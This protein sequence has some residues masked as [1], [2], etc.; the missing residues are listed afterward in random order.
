MK[1]KKIL[2]ATFLIANL[3]ALPLANA[4]KYGWSPCFKNNI[5]FPGKQYSIQVGMTHLHIKDGYYAKGLAQDEEHCDL[6]GAADNDG[7]KLENITIWDNDLKD[8]YVIEQLPASC[9]EVQANETLTLEGTYDVGN[10]VIKNL[11]CIISAE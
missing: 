3:T 10:H 6:F 5:K 2:L 8:H 1:N 4:G 7:Y 11:N 9:A